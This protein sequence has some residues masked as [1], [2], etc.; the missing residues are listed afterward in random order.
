MWGLAPFW[1]VLPRVQFML[2][3]V[4]KDKNIEAQA[5]K[6]KTTSAL[7]AFDVHMAR[8]VTLM[9]KTQPEAI[10]A[11]RKAFDGKSGQDLIEIKVA[12][13]GKLVVKL[14]MKT[15]VLTFLM[16]LRGGV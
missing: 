2:E 7:F 11:A 10:G 14:S 16:G 4:P 8:A 5:A 6:G 9:A 3:W 12:S 15:Q 13:G 1:S